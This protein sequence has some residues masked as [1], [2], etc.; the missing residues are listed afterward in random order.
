MLTLLHSLTFLWLLA[1]AWHAFHRLK[2]HRLDSI[3]AVVIVHFILCGIPIALDVLAGKPSFTEEPGLGDAAEDIPT[4]VAFCLFVSFCPI[5]WLWAGK[6]AGRAAP[7]IYVEYSHVVR[8]PIYVVCWLLATLP[9]LLVLA[10]PERDEYLIYGSPVRGTLAQD[11][12]DWHNFVAMS[13][14]VGVL[15]I[16]VLLSVKR[17]VRTQDWL[18]AGVLTLFDCWINGKR[19]IVAVAI[20][21]LGYTFWSKGLLVGRQLKLA[22]TGGVLFLVAFSFFYQS[23]VRFAETPFQVGT[24]GSVYENFRGVFFRDDRI[25]MTLYAEIHPERMRILEYRGQS[26]VFNLL[27][28][29]PRSIWPEKPWPYSVYFTSAMLNIYPPRSLNWGMTTS[30]LEEAVANFG[31]LGILIGP[32]SIACLCRLGDSYRWPALTIVTVLVAVLLM[33]VQLSAFMAIF[34]FWL[35]LLLLPLLTPRHGSLGTQ[36]HLATM[37]G[38]PAKQKAQYADRDGRREFDAR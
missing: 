20:I 3:N 31:W 14:M 35:A 10:S 11:P 22:L 5:I 17:T 32:L 4:A 34:L 9:V 7:K 12:S 1:C 25:K 6:S 29:V 28:F 30:W 24:T 18:A 13:A 37:T 27:F 19:A 16:A 8:R 15:A 26:V 21:A 2:Q 23:K 38:Q 33:S 36:R